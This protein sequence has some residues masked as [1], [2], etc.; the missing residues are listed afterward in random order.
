LIKTVRSELSISFWKSDLGEI[1]LNQHVTVDDISSDRMAD[2][3]KESS[4]IAGII[5]CGE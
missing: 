1:A 2:I 5:G 3:R 4:G